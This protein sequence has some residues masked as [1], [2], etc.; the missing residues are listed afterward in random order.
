MFVSGKTLALTQ[1]GMIWR[2]LIWRELMA[3]QVLLLTSCNE[4][5]LRSGPGAEEVQDQGYGY[6]VLVQR[7]ISCSPTST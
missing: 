2:E 1:C 6:L 4:G 5:E 7:I 3:Q